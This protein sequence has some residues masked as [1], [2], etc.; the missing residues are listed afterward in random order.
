MATTITQNVSPTGL[1][2][3]T[4]LMNLLTAQYGAGLTQRQKQYEAG[5]GKLEQALQIAQGPEFEAFPIEQYER[6]KTKATSAGLSRLISSGLMGTTRVT[7]PERA[8]ETEVGVPFYKGLAEAKAG[9]ISGALGNIAQYQAQFPN[10]YP[11]AG[12]LAYLATGGFG[13]L[14]PQQKLAAEELPTL[15]RLATTGGGSTGFMQGYGG[16]GGGG[17]G[18]GSTTFDQSFGIS[19][20]STISG[21]G[22]G[23]YAPVGAGV[24][25]Y[26]PSTGGP[27]E[28]AYVGGGV[29][30]TSSLPSGFN[31]AG[32]EVSGAN[33]PPSTSPV[34]YVEALDWERWRKQ[35]P[36][37]TTQQW[38]TQ[39]SPVSGGGTFTG[40]GYT[41]SW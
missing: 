41:G 24:S 18:G 29:Y 27:I 33:T 11:E 30:G 34:S 10:I 4:G 12:T 23:G 7:E 40:A 39:Y 15:A 3:I 16:G 28:Q 17:G 21:G 37:G 32:I 35:N 38:R 8:F 19:P 25:R 13:Q 22:Y 20:T 26:E 31:L 14:S 1:T 5:L 2:D 9:R 36:T 6:A